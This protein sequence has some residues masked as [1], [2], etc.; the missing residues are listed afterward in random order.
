M[1]HTEL[2]KIYFSYAKIIIDKYHFIRQVTWAI[3]C[4]RKKLQRSMSSSLRKYYKR[5][6]R[7]ILTRY[8]KLN[9]GNRKT[10]D[11]MLL[12]NDDLRKAHFLKEKFYDICQDR[13]YS[14]QRTDFLD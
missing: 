2:A 1:C 10:Y 5:S 12:Y 6:K 9:E 8:Q 4:V 13:K 14:R 7:L 3:E 11:L